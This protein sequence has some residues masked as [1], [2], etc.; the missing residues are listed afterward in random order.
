MALSVREKLTLQKI[1]REKSGE[2]EQGGMKVREKLAA[3]RAMREALEK[4]NQKID[5]GG[6]SPLLA[7]LIAGKFNDLGPVQF[8]VKL[9]QVVA[10]IDGLI[11]P[12]K[13]PT[14]GYIE[15]QVEKG[16]LI[17]EDAAAILEAARVKQPSIPN[18]DKRKLN[19]ILYEYGKT[20]H[21]HIPLEDIFAKIIRAGYVPLQEDGTE[22]DGALTGAKGQ[23]DIPLAQKQARQNGATVYPEETWMK[24]YM[25]IQWYRDTGVDEKFYEFNGYVA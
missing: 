23:A 10:S 20:R 19:D 16:N 11:E 12:V 1:V 13:Q 15:A 17:L 5:A 7:D 24:Q 8:I 4:L 18:G 21:R 9:R 14:I 22:W 2:L 6:T 25:H 3:Q